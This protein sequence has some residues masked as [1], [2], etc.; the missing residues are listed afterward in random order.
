M[1]SW[2]MKLSRI[3]CKFCSLSL[4][5]RLYAAQF[6]V[7]FAYIVGFSIFH[8]V[9][10]CSDLLGLPSFVLGFGILLH[11][12]RYYIVACRVPCALSLVGT[13]T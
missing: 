12:R 4:V 9:Y 8:V 6:V 5:S 1:N 13:L 7:H 3:S 10:L 2:K 11:W